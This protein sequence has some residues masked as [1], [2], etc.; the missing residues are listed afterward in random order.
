MT[1]NEI[2]DLI[3]RHQPIFTVVNDQDIREDVFTTDNL[4]YLDDG[5]TLR[6]IDKGTLRVSNFE[7]N[8]LFNNS[9]DAKEYAKFGFIYRTEKFPYIPYEEAIE[10]KYQLKDY[11][12]F[13]AHDGLWWYIVYDDNKFHLYKKDDFWDDWHCY[14][15]PDT[16]EGYQEIL[17]LAVKQFNGVED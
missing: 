17:E 4:Y 9:E 2:L 6:C 15:V 14:E 13:M 1:Q 16:R 11:L 5:K 8:K 7:F 10:H 3:K 12:Y